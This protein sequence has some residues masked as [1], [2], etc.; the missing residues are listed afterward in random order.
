METFSLIML[1]IG[2]FLLGCG[3]TVAMV[4]LIPLSALERAQDHGRFAGLRPV[5]SGGGSGKVQGAPADLRGAAQG[6]PQA[7]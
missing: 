6:T 5:A 3:V 1:A 4:R 2:L 7:A